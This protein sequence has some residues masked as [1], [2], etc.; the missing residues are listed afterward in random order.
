MAN[1]KFF[2]PCAMILALGF[3]SFSHADEKQA[4]REFTLKVLP[5]LKAKCFAC[6]GEGE[7]KPKGGLDVRN[8]AALLKGGD[9]GP[10]INLGKPDDSL[11]Y[12]AVKW[13]GLEMPPKENDRLSA[14]QTEMIR[15]WIAAGMPWPDP[16]TQKKYLEEE[17]KT[18]LTSDGM[19]AKTSGGLSDE[20]TY[21]RY[22]PED[23]WAFQAVKKPAIPQGTSNPIDHFVQSK[24]EKTAITGAP[25]ADPRT[26]VRRATF[27]LLGLP[28]TPEEVDRFL[29]AWKTDPTQAWENLID[30]LLASPQYGERWAT[31]WFDVARYADTG[32]MA[33]DYERSNMWRYRDYVIR[34]FNADKPYDRF[35]TEQIAGDQLADAAVLKRFNGNAS[36]VAAVRVSGEYTEEEAEWVVA[37]S[38]L[39]MGPWD[40]AMIMAPQARQ[41]YLDDLVN[42]VGQTFLA[43]TMRCFKCHDHKFDPLPT[44][45]YYRIY[46]AFAGTQIAERPLRFTKDEN[47]EG[48]AEGKAFVEKMMK[49]A[50]TEKEKILAKQEAA[51]RKWYEEHKLPYKNEAARQSDPDEKKPPRHVGLDHVDQG[52]LKVREQDEWIWQRALERYQPMVNGVYDGP[53]QKI[54]WNGARKLRMPPKVNTSWI[55][56]SR[57]LMGG[58]LEAPGDKVQP[59]VL[60]AALVPVGS[61]K[62]DPYVLPENITQRRLGLA[63]WITDPR[64]PLTTRAIVNR[65]WQY[66]FGKPIAGNPNNF[67]V[68]GAKPSH[69]EL[70]DWLAADLVE[71]GWTVKRL[72]KLIMTSQTYQMSNQHP[73]NEKLRTTDPNN[74]LLAY[75]P[76]R[77]LTAEEVRDAM[78]HITGELNPVMGGL[79]AMPEINLEVAFQPRMIQFSLAPA[80]QPSRTPQERNRRSVYAYRGRG[81][82]DPFLEVFNQP[83][84]NDSCDL[85]DSASVSPQAFSLLNSNLMTDRSIALAL[86]VGKD[87]KGLEAQ[88]KRA[89]QLVLGRAPSTVEAE[90]LAKYVQ[91]MQTYHRDNK[92]KSVK[93]PTRIRRSLV[94][95]LSGQEFEYDEIL[96]VFEKYV[97][98]AKPADVSAET[99]ALA[100][101]CLLLLNSNEFIYLY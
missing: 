71:H 44:R 69:P 15:S 5:L 12:K 20:W 79:P 82:T 67:G 18:I 33:N 9:S 89:F 50:T 66:H 29:A 25:R 80:Y 57:I 81:L 95:E 13:D 75:F 10:S 7:K 83:N 32:G 8:R 58:T 1:P 86:R 39:R 90:R 98:D 59:G 74:D 73:H 24:L 84:P 70:L 42:A 48:F 2:L 31:H 41:I 76:T 54:A 55:P 65:V 30:R 62:D 28:P 46:A 78:L 11:F 14:I 77:R 61:P 96:P 91:K 97:P 99:R 94:E 87:A 43:T 35:V 26:L 4:E 3:T 36:K 49:Y 52:Q 16:A 19:L 93:Y 68:K 27:D 92:A 64:N 72:H 22:K 23:L 47:R 56:D 40:N 53:D 17:R 34:S 60:S 38:F 21:R 85:R 100:D 37:T 63:Q 88:V 6:H 101:L 45:D 51:A